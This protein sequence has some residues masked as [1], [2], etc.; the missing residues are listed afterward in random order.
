RYP[1]VL[2]MTA[3]SDSRV[4]PMHARKFTARLQAA[5]D[6]PVLLRIETRAG[7]GQGKPASKQADELADSWAFL[8]WQLGLDP[9]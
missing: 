4:D 9:S 7:H 1:A 3:E 8:A 5:T 2:V 6:Q